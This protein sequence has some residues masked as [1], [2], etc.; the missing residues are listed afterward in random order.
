M[1]PGP[2]TAR[3]RGTTL[4][5]A[6]SGTL[7]SA[8]LA[9]LQLEIVGLQRELAI[10]EEI[11]STWDAVHSEFKRAEDAQNVLAAFFDAPDGARHGQFESFAA[12]LPP[13]NF[14]AISFATYVSAAERES[15]ERG[16]APGGKPGLR[17]WELGAGGLPSAAA[18]REAYLPVTH[19]HP[20]DG[21]Q[22]ALG[23]DLLS[24]SRRRQA[25]LE[26]IRTGK[27]VRTDPIRLV[28]APEQWAFLVFKPVYRGDARVA[29]FGGKPPRPAGVVSAVYQFGPV[30][31]AAIRGRAIAGWQIALFDSAE[32][33]FPVYVHRPGAG[34]PEGPD[35]DRPLDVVASLPGARL[36][37]MV[38][39]NHELTAVFFGR[40]D[41]ATWW[42]E[43][44]A[45]ILATLLTGLLLTTGLAWHDDR[46]HRSRA[47]LRK[48]TEEGR[49]L[50]EAADRATSAQ[51][52]VLAAASHDLR[53]PV[54]AAALFV[55]SL[56]H[57]PLDQR[58]R[59]TVG[60]LDQCI[61]SVRALLDGLLDLSKL[62]AGQISPRIETFG[63]RQTFAAIE[64]EFA[65]QALAKGLRIKV[66]SPWPDILVR[67]DPNLV[68]TILR[69][70]VSN[71]VAYTR[72]G[73]VLVGTRRHRERVAIQVWDTGIGIDEDQL[74]RI[75]EE[76]YQ[77]ENPQRDRGKGFGLG[78]AI[79]RRAADLLECRLTCVS[80]PGRG[81]LFEFD[82]PYSRNGIVEAADVS[83][84]AA[85]SLSGRHF[86][87]VEDDPLVAE[88]LAEWLEE[89][90]GFVSR[91]ASAE[92]ALADEDAAGADCY[93]SDYRL[94]GATDGIEFLDTM[95]ER[96]GHAIVG[97]LLTGDTSPAFIE[98]AGRSGWRVLFKPIDPT[99]L[100]KALE[101]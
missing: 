99:L 44:N 101:D 78:L 87:V 97:V 18:E 86:V 66:R 59:Q 81:T 90:G 34:E 63:L 93:I 48:A 8:G 4:A 33:S 37:S 80:R 16:L 41:A 23:F 29:G 65:P 83:P 74:H 40:D 19:L 61:G 84:V 82:L 70:L 24:E 89:G 46:A 79:A 60:Q 45:T 76:F 56:K 31:E 1:R 73:G 20:A 88:S 68:L 26:A 21:N 62:D 49:A 91:Y 72:R 38:D 47:R 57:S 58:Q 52:R 28:Q 7:A 12:S 96:A 67:S 15:F 32:P 55:D 92:E 10:G 27:T 22:R 5:I 39:M 98:R 36:A 64:T 2:A 42:R 13:A 71:A 3:L 77:V 9:W 69:N 14:Q 11:R 35:L 43:I 6:L 25:L 17:I 53:Q 50:Q 30:L 100:P 51:S 54:Q 94:P 95:R 75:F 85:D